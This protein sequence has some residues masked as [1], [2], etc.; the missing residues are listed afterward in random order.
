MTKKEIEKLGWRKYK[1]SEMVYKYA[2]CFYQK[3][4]YEHEKDDNK[5]SAEIVQYDFTSEFNN[6]KCPFKKNWE[7]RVY[8][9]WEISVTGQTIQINNYS[10]DKLDFK[11]ME[12]DARKI[13]KGL[14]KI[15]NNYIDK[16]ITM[17]AMQS[18]CCGG[19]F[20]IK[21]AYKCLVCKKS[22]DIEPADGGKKISKT[23]HI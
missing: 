4:F 22:C 10:Y 9:P 6:K 5:G 2:E 20:K 12:K 21:H 19:G 8:I 23:L 7:L 16:T 17:K 15:N 18:S 1:T 3:I 11:K 14:I 13:M